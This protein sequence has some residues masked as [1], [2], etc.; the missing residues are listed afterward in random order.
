MKSTAAE[1]DKYL[2]LLDE[3]LR[4]LERISKLDSLR[5]DLSPDK[6]TWSPAKILAHVRSCADVWGET[7]KAMLQFDTPELADIHPH[8]RQKST[9]YAEMTFQE[10]FE[11]FR[12]QRKELLKIVKVIPVEGWERSAIIGNRRHTV[13]TQVRRMALHESEHCSQIESIIGEV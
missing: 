4:R 2:R 6:Q 7:V 3:N 11:A 5:L 10:S 13:F 1:I 8:T 9:G 12:V